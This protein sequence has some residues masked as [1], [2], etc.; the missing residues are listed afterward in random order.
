MSYAH[1][2]VFIYYPTP[3]EIKAYLMG[4][5][6]NSFDE[7]Q[8]GAFKESEA[9]ARNPDDD[10]DAWDSECPE[11]CDG[12][13]GELN[14]ACCATSVRVFAGGFCDDYT[15]C[16]FAGTCVQDGCGTISSPSCCCNCGSYTPGFTYSRYPIY[17]QSGCF[18]FNPSGV[19]LDSSGG[20]IGC[21][22]HDALT[23]ACGI[24]I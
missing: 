17:L 7:S 9:G 3:E 21:V 2:E 8:A 24:C 18:Q 4:T 11:D 20:A 6:A 1:A 13:F 19:R 16:L 15:A 10:D 22:D 12:S 14:T 5:N 23:A